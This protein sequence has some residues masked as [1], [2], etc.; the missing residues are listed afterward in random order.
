MRFGDEHQTLKYKQSPNSKNQTFSMAEL[1]QV[2]FSPEVLARIAPDVSLQRHL[3]LGVRPNLRNFTEFKPVEVSNSTQFQDN[4]DNVFSS[5]VVKSGSTTIINTITLG[6][7]ENFNSNESEYATIYPCVEILR[8]RLGAPT[9][10]EMILSQDLFET[11][12][13]NK[14]IPSTSLKINNLGISIKD[15]QTTTT[16]QPTPP[17][18]TQI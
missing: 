4:N 11:L 2:T 8:G 1:K 9:D 6:I 12:Y 15:D 10:E 5:S 18:I 17:Y 13:H 3:A 14:I 7:V 16:S